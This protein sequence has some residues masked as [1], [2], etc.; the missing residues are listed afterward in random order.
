MHK[1][2]GI[3]IRK[4]KSK[5]AEV[6]RIKKNAL[7]TE[8]LSLNSSYAKVD[9]IFHQVPN[10]CSHNIDRLKEHLRSLQQI[11]LRREGLER[12]VRAQLKAELGEDGE[13]GKE[14]ETDGRE[15]GGEKGKRET[16]EE[17]GDGAERRESTWETE[18]VTLQADLAKVSS[19]KFYFQFCKL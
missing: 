19:S 11:S 17:G 2:K 9:N 8:L 16:R 5:L 6:Y 7:L 12:Q 10:S 15:G 14:E 3:H 1:E 18:V 13:R 4:T